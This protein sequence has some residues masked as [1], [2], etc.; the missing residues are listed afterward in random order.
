MY[1][2]A[3]EIVMFVECCSVKMASVVMACKM[4]CFAVL[5]VTY[6]CDGYV[7]EQYAWTASRQYGNIWSSDHNDS[8]PMR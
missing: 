5:L 2:D 6:S 7:L 1:S 8:F 3:Q 4:D